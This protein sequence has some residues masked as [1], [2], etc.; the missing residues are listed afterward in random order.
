MSDKPSNKQAQLDLLNSN[1]PVFVGL[2]G[3]KMIDLDHDKSLAVFEFNVSK[4]YCH[5]VDVVQG[6]FIT[7]MLDTAMSHA[8]FAV[9]DNV[10]GLSSLEI[11]TSYLE[12]TRAGKLRAEGY[13]VKGGYKTGFLEGRLYNEAGE[14]TA[15]ASSVAKIV[16][17]ATD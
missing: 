4:D 14:L 2:L 12:S 1:A 8:V 7:S 15:T 9:N 13:V 5:S 10:V 11:K 16:R 17:K 6:G 3:G